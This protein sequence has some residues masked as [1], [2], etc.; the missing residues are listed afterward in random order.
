MATIIFIS[1][2]LIVASWLY[3]YSYIG[4]QL[5]HESQKVGEAFYHTVWTDLKNQDKRSLVM[6]LINGQRPQY[7]MAGKFYRFTLFG[8]CDSSDYNRIGDSLA[9]CRRIFAI[10]GVMP[11]QDSPKLFKLI[12]L[13]FL[14]LIL[15]QAWDTYDVLHNFETLVVSATEWP[16]SVSVT[17]I[18]VLIRTNK[19]LPAVIEKIQ[20]DINGAISFE[21]DEEKRR[22]RKYNN[23][24]VYFGKYVSVFAFVVA[25]MMFARPLIDLMVNSGTENEQLYRPSNNV[26]IDEVNSTQPFV[27]PFRAHVFFDYRYNAKIYTMIYIFQLPAAYVGVYHAA[28]ASLI[29]TSTLHV[30]GKLSVLACRIRMSLTQSSGHFQQRMKT[31]VI[32]HLELLE[33]SNILNDCFHHILLIE[34]LNCSFRLGVSM[35][36]VIIM[37]AKDTVAAVNFILYSIIVAAWLYLY[38]YIGE[39]LVHESQQVGEAF[40]VTDWTN[41]ANRDRRSLTI[42]LINGQKAE[43]LTAGK[44]YRFTLFGFSNIVKSSMAFLSVLRTT[45]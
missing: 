43:Y 29:V 2:T 32:E 18:L 36:V 14:F 6:C 34:Y 26:V 1:Y 45:V 13:Y 28:E 41:I 11:P 20:N 42:C 19:R 31:I 25:Y 37:L 24:S 5:A 40:Y 12:V 35:Y 10:G 3:L 9:Y 17:L 30:C 15:M 44:F 4:E 21:N 22:Y 23:I 33:F 38:S 16:V 27:L 39:Q 7:L 8:F